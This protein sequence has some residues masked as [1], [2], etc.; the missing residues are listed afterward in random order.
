MLNKRRVKKKRT[1]AM[2]LSEQIT[3]LIEADADKRVLEALTRYA[4]TIAT[5]HR[6][7]LSLLLR[8]LPSVK[9][10]EGI[11]MGIYVTGKNKGARCNKIGKYEGYCMFHMD[12][13]KKFQPVQIVQE[14]P[15]HNHGVPPLYKEDCPA[16][17]QSCA[18]KKKLV[19]DFNGIL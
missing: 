15:K 17:C 8:D 18:P 13:R 16:C 1:H 19:I 7:P 5:V 3:K 11:C 4:E 14:G 9:P 10:G 6:I 2:S 12:Q